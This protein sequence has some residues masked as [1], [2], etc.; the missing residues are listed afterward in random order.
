MV[1][2][3]PCKAVGTL[4]VPYVQ[5]RC[6]VTV[7]VIALSPLVSEEIPGSEVRVI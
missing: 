4:C 6:G 3:Y 2:Y 5:S 7:T 1:R